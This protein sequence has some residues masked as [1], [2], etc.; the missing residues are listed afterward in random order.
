MGKKSLGTRVSIDVLISLLCVRRNRCSTAWEADPDV[1][2][3]NPRSLLMFGLSGDNGDD[4]AVHIIVHQIYAKA[5]YDRDVG[6]C[7][8]AL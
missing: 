4:V 3:E 1:S 5:L 7:T 2:C 8:A 6:L